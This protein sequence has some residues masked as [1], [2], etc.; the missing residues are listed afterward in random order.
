MNEKLL[1]KIE[2][3]LG[4]NNFCKE[5]GIYQFDI[6]ADYRDVLENSSLVE[7]G[8]E[9]MD[10]VR[11]NFYSHFQ[12]DEA[13][14]QEE[15]LLIKLIKDGLDVE[16]DDSLLIKWIGENFSF[17]FPYDH[18]LKQSVLVNVS[19]DTGESNYDYTK[20]NFFQDSTEKPWAISDESSLYFLC[21]QQGYGKK[22]IKPSFSNPGKHNGSFL[23]SIYEE[24]LNVTTH[25]NQLVFFVKMTLGEYIDL[26]ENPRNFTVS[27]GVNCG[28][29]DF[30]SGAGSLL[31]VNLE[32]DVVIPAKKLSLHIDG[33]VGY[34]VAE[35]YGIASSFWK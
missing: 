16:V 2:C 33:A 22:R 34:S 7:I 3:I 9:S 27:K 14:L 31:G 12:E 10:T 29:V 30:W 6:Y 21:K 1:E 15:D 8:K 35:I 13:I 5:G 25:M 28:L 4:D 11:E 32:K 20:N 18:Y 26:K 23:H 17:N 19:V 24:C